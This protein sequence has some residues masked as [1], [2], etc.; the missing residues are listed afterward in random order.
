MLLKQFQ[1]DPL[2]FIDEEIRDA[3]FGEDPGFARMHAALVLLCHRKRWTEKLNTLEKYRCFLGSTMSLYTFQTWIIDGNVVM[4]CAAT[5]NRADGSAMEAHMKTG[6]KL[7]RLGAQDALAMEM[8]QLRTMVYGLAPYEDNQHLKEIFLSD[9]L[10][11]DEA[12]DFDDPVDVRSWMT[13]QLNVN[14]VF[15]P[16]LYL[17]SSQVRRN[18]RGK[19]KV[20]Q[21]EWLENQMAKDW[22]PVNFYY[23]V[24]KKNES[25]LSEMH[26]NRA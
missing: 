13:F 11:D 4:Q 21:L 16:R 20:E 6:A 3:L 15:A 17:Q 23:H 19:S 8:N 14:V 25:M 12:Y 10:E 2:R 5:Q 1:V 7:M 24:G 26:A 9:K 18:F 22:A